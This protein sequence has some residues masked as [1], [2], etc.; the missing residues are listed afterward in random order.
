MKRILSTLSQ[1]WPEYLLEILVVIIGILAA[2]SLNKWNENQKTKTAEVLSLERFLEDIKSDTARF[3][4][5][6]ESYRR[7]ISR[8]DSLIEM[9][10]KQKTTSD[11]QQ[12]I[13]KHVINFYLIEA[14]TTTFDEM[15]N[16][17]RFYNFSNESLRTGLDKYYRDIEKWSRYIEK[18]NAQLRQLMTHPDYNDYW[19]AQQALWA[20]ETINSKKFPWIASRYSN[21]IK[22]IE[23]LIYRARNVYLSSRGTVKYLDRQADLMINELTDHLD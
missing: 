13:N 17:G 7:R 8:C 2:F 14:N 22:D 3:E 20:G 1:K 23:A 9:L 15:I 6:N 12:I 16:T 18:D 4:F 21:E 10:Q 19:L 11:R 5:L